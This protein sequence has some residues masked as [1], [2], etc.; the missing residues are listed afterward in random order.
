MSNESY[1]GVLVNEL[2]KRVALCGFVIISVIY[3]VNLNPIFAICMW[4]ELR[5]RPLILASHLG[6]VPAVRLSLKFAK[7]MTTN[8][9]NGDSEEFQKFM[10]TPNLKNETALDVAVKEGHVKVAKLLLENVSLE[11]L[12]SKRNNEGKLLVTKLYHPEHDDIILDT[13]DKA[14]NAVMHPLAISIHEEDLQQESQ[15][16]YINSIMGPLS[17]PQSHVND[18]RASLLKLDQGEVELTPNENTI[19]HLVSHIGDIRYARD[20][21]VKHPTLVYRCNSEGETPAYIAAR[22]G[23]V[24]ILAIIINYF[25][26]NNDDTESLLKRSMDNHN[27]LHIAIQNHHVGV[28]FYLMREVPQLANLVNNSK[29]SP[30]YLAAERRYYHLLNHILTKCETKSFEGP[31]GKTAL[32]AAAISGSEG[33]SKNFL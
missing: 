2:R 31:Q 26:M 4:C 17:Y 11:C 14:T 9:H 6:D 29:E 21:L 8:L 28:V 16:V 25:R 22:E 15:Q 33:N 24:D 3:I 20:I 30:V 19:L 18:T 5:D 13:F 12:V 27:A 7:K 23:H 10:W 1:Y 32:H